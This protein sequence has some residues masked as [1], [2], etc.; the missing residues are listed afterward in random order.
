[1]GDPSAQAHLTCSSWKITRET[2]KSCRLTTIGR[3]WNVAERMLFTVL[4]LQ[5]NRRQDLDL[6]NSLRSRRRIVTWE[7]TEKHWKLRFVSR[8]RPGLWQVALATRQK[9]SSYIQIGNR[10]PELFAAQGEDCRLVS[11]CKEQNRGR[12]KLEQ[13]RLLLSVTRLTSNREP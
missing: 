11:L 8:R 7:K 13:E 6:L 2:L 1:M 10:P 3:I 4:R 5:L 12:T 9:N